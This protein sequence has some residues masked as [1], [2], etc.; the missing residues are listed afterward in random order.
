[1]NNPIIMAL[2]P[3]V[4][5]TLQRQLALDT[6]GPSSWPTG[7]VVLSKVGDATEVEIARHAIS[8]S[9]KSEFAD[10]FAEA[11]EWLSL[12]MKERGW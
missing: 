12:R 8:S 5:G 7:I 11:I 3:H 4:A 10:W 6:Y 1:M 9:G 2:V